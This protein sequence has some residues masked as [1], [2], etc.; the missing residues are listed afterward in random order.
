MW[1]DIVEKIKSHGYWRVVVRPTQF[2]KDLIPSLKECLRLIDESKVSLRGWDYPHIEQR[3]EGLINGD[4][5]VESST[6]WR[7]YLEAW[8]FHQSGQFA[9]LFGCREDWLPRNEQEYFRRGA[10]F[11]G[12]FLEP[13]W[14]VYRTTE[15]YEFA[16][17]L[18]AKGIFGHSMHVSVELHNMR[19][20]PLLITNPRRGSLHGNYICHIDE[21][22]FTKTIPV[23]ALLAKSSEF[24]LENIV[25]FFERFN[26]D[27]MPIEVIKNDQRQLLERRL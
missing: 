6:D 2:Q 15:I 14:M 13:I 8:R 21:I 16:A 17:R 11:T 27:R 10:S 24:A 23:E 12:P 9:H 18:A 3:G 1:E 26:W 25:Y 20:R 7:E 5:W 4:D 19:D 22:A